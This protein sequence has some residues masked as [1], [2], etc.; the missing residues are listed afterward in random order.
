MAAIGHD[1]TEQGDAAE[2]LAALRPTGIDSQT[3]AAYLYVVRKPGCSGD[4]VADH[5]GV[6]DAEPLLADLLSERLIG[7]EESGELRALSPRSALLRRIDEEEAQLQHR[8]TQLLTGR[9]AAELL[10]DEYEQ[11]RVYREDVVEVLA[12]RHSVMDR[13]SELVMSLQR[14]SRAMITTEQDPESLKS[15]KAQDLE[16]IDRGLDVR[17]IVLAG[18]LRRSREL[19]DYQ[20]EM[21]DAGAQVRVATSLPTRLTIWDRS[22]ALLPIDPL[23]PSRGACL[24]TMPGL[25][26]A[27]VQTFDA[28]WEAAEPLSRYVSGSTG[29]RTDSED[30]WTPSPLEHEVLRLLAGGH[31]DESI[32]RR[33][34]MSLRSVRRVIAKISQELDTSSRFQMGVRA[35]QRGLI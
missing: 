26:D 7:E 11:A 12:D 6:S 1:E 5:L 13:I 9:R 17:T 33:V 19:L 4:E 31:K 2:L 27:L 23:D 16:L 35:I 22:A 24:A 30:S 15:A 8:R 32:A 25:V 14:E 21:A 18:H 28:C 3:L 10:L 34:G 29:S 20:L